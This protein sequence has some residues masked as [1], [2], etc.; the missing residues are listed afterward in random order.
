MTQAQ[1]VTFQPDIASAA[2]LTGVFPS[3]FS[4]TLASVR[5]DYRLSATQNLFLR[6][7]HDNNQS[8]GSPSATTFQQPSNWVTNTNWA[9]Q[10]AIGATSILTPNPVNDARVGFITGTMRRCRS[11]LH[12]G[13]PARDLRR[14][15][16]SGNLIGAAGSSKTRSSAVLRMIRIRGSFAGMSSSTAFPV[17][18]RYPPYQIRSR[19]RNDQTLRWLLGVLPA[20]M[21]RSGF[22]RIH[23]RPGVGDGALQR[24]S[25]SA[26]AD[27]RD[28][29]CTES[30]GFYNTSPG[31]YGGVGIGQ[32]Q[33]PGP[34]ERGNFD[35]NNRPRG[36][37]QD[38]WKVR[39][40]LTLNYGLAYEADLGLFNSSLN[41]PAYLV[42]ILGFYQ[43]DRS[44]PAE[45]LSRFRVRLESGEERQD[46]DSGW[47]RH[48]LGQHQSLL[49]L[50]GRSRHRAAGRHA[51]DCG[52]QC[53]YQHFPGHSGLRRKS[54]WDPSANW[55]KVFRRST[56]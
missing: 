6:Y 17:A 39:P 18:E 46:R 56:S 3:P 23:Q 27:H 36:Y 49:P 9:D 22:L 28:Q 34:Y 5:L 42:P 55:C 33:T 31:I 19:L 25:D 26:D 13:M 50:A 45:F 43:P 40:N 30:T 29:R 44:Q 15:R 21:Y 53:V 51:A 35:H 2:P 8:Y 32:Y 37:F 10:V 54:E 47:R 4:Q 52:G 20:P 14:W 7:S 41:K 1:A 12:N 48:L 11:R 38:T 24:I 16:A